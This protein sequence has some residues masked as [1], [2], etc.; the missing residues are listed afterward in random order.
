VRFRRLLGGF[1]FA[2]IVV[3]GFEPQLLSLLFDDRSALAEAL[4]RAPDLQAPAYPR[5][6]EEVARRTKQGESIAILVPMRHWN[7]GYSYAYFRASYFLA[8]RNVIP[9][10]DAD[11]TLQPERLNEAELVAVWQMPPPVGP[12]APVWSGNGGVLL[13]RA[14]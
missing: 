11:D 5:F 9:L 13:R 4:T 12:F 8:G 6:L 1:L 10:V 3:G 7:G 14:R 2:A